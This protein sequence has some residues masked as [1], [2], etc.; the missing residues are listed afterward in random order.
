M[1][2]ILNALKKVEQDKE[3]HS[4]L[5]R[6][7]FSD[8]KER[9]TLHHAVKSTWLR[10]HPIRWTMAAAV[11]ILLGLGFFLYTRPELNPEVPAGK[12]RSNPAYSQEDL[13]AAIITAPESDRQLRPTP[14]DR[15][16]LKGPGPKPVVPNGSPRNEVVDVSRAIN[17]NPVPSM[18]PPPTLP[19]QPAAAEPVIRAGT[20]RPGKAETPPA[21]AKHAS[22]KVNSAAGEKRSFA[23]A[24]VMTD[25]RLK[26][27]A[28][29]YAAEPT[30]RMAVV[31]NRVLREGAT[32]EGL[33]IVGIGED[34][35]YVKEGTRILKV[36]FGAP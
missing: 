17:R 6:V 15:I 16:N 28:I 29:V 33:S 2:T 14:R 34:A 23:N 20:P 25:G 12:T 4:D 27:Q 5:N 8:L 21:P 18:P 31:N 10:Y 35:L 22:A 3:D 13:S 26:V 32:I 36:P 24:D 19:A 30:E 7:L 11:T 1:S 9:R